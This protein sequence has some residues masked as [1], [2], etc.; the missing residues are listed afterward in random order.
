MVWWRKSSRSAALVAVGVLAVAGC[1]V[2]SDEPPSSTPVVTAQIPVANPAGERA[3]HTATSLASGL[4]LVVGGCVV[5]GCGLATKSTALVGDASTVRAGPPLNDARDS[6]TAVQVADGTVVVAG[7]FAAEGTPPLDSVEILEPRAAAWQTVGDLVTARGGHA[8]AALG[9]DRMLVAG[10][11]VAPQTYTNTT[12][13]FDARTEQFRPGPD[14]PVAVDGLAASS[15]D[16]G[17]VLVTGGQRRPGVA[18]AR[19]AVVTPE[20]ELRVVGP[21]LHARFKHVSVTL[22]SGEV[23]I[24]GGTDD[25]QRLLNSTEI[26]DPSTGTF[27]AGPT[28]TTGRYKLSG[29]AAVLPDGRVVVAGGGSGV[30]VL[31]PSRLTSERLLDIP[32]MRSSFSTVN[33]VGDADLLIL[34]G[35]DENIALTDLFTIVAIGDVPRA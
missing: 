8:A 35:Y 16:D 28:M 5:D 3:A 9:G 18:S 7:G 4:V 22:P 6:H 20:G 21:M 33:L 24:I 2:S 19:A 10:G 15:L 14:L 13:I 25:D 23:L 29:S 1:T 32:P 30:E 27:R 17:S 11:W 34:G 26:F 31:D 12:E